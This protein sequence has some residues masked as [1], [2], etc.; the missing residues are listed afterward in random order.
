VRGNSIKKQA[1]GDLFCWMEKIKVITKNNW[2][3]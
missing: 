1:I 2:L 3:R